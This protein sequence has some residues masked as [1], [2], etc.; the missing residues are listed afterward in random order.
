MELEVLEI[1]V[2]QVQVVLVQELG[3]LEIM[4]VQVHLL[5]KM[6][7]E[8]G[9]LRLV[10]E[11]LEMLLGREQGME[12]VHGLVVQVLVHG[13]MEQE[14]VVLVQ[15]LG[16]REQ[17]EQE[18]GMETEQVHLLLIIQQMDGVIII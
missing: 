8:H 9:Q 13:Q 16:V 10:L 11:V 3:V 1:M 6:E 18:Q 12:L 7:Q 2:V 4:V 5:E 17:Q 14:Q 15:E